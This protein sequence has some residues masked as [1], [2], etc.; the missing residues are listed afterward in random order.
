MSLAGLLSLPASLFLFYRKLFRLLFLELCI[1]Q[2]LLIDIFRI[3]IYPYIYII[4]S[5]PSSDPLP[6]TTSE[7]NRDEVSNSLSDL[8][9]IGT[10]IRAASHHY[11][12][13]PMSLK[14]PNHQSEAIRVGREGVV[15]I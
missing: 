6:R 8:F 14:H 4:P 5:F 3:I 11:Y 12:L 1:K 13:M 9:S 10:F 2:I 7:D 15:I